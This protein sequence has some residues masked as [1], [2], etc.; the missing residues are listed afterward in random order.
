M[1]FRLEEKIE[2]HITDYP[3]VMSL[4]NKC[5]GNEIYKQ[6]K[7]S[8]IYFDNKNQDM[9]LDSEE[10]ILP[11]KRCSK[12]GLVYQGVEIKGGFPQKI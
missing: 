7:S 9:F 10:G 6:R 2:L 1:A 4:I 11:R 8:S 12:A 5:N 3:K